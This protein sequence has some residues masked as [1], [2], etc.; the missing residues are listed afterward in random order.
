MGAMRLVGANGGKGA[1]F[2][3]GLAFAAGVGAQ[4]PSL[5][6]EVTRADG[7]RAAGVAVTF[8]AARVLGI[9][10][11]RAGAESVDV[12]QTSTDADGRFRLEVPPSLAGT[13]LVQAGPEVGAASP[14]VAGPAL[15]RITLAPGARR[16]FEVRGGPAGGFEVAY[17]GPGALAPLR[18]A[19]TGTRLSVPAVPGHGAVL[20]TPSGFVSAR[21]G[22]SYLPG[23]GYDRERIHLLAVPTSPRSVRWA[24]PLHAP[25]ARRGALTGLWGRETTAWHG[26]GDDGTP[27]VAAGDETGFPAAAEEARRVEV[28]EGAGRAVLIA[29]ATVELAGD[30]VTFAVAEMLAV[31]G[32]EAVLPRW[33][34]A[35][36]P[37]LVI[38]DDA[39]GPRLLG[40]GLSG[41]GG[42]LDAHRVVGRVRAGDGALA[43]GVTVRVRPQTEAGTPP[44]PAIEATTG[45]D[46]GFVLPVRLP[47]GAYELFAV[48]PDSRQAHA[49]FAVEGDD[50]RIDVQLEDGARLH[51][52]L[53]DADGEPAAGVRVEL[54]LGAD[55]VAASFGWP[56]RF[57]FT[58]RRGEFE[59]RGL[60]EGAAYEIACDSAAYGGVAANGATPGEGA[61]LLQLRAGAAPR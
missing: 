35:D 22:E 36:T 28:G 48:A 55:D 16:E 54:L 13:C 33:V 7:T 58:D 47:R 18:L 43:A 45:D 25:V 51:G 40:A 1:W 46:G 53:V 61:V 56:E 41:A 50:A 59:F 2:A 6:G 23:S 11:L 34:S 10:G 31:E 4:A 5:R 38:V 14:V 21:S 57:V 42:S 49:M 37:H 32:S 15:V 20:L 9:A 39:R 27:F 52:L 44:A 17:E 3:L 30:A 26:Q 24:A 29:H 8:H 60:R 19:A 12:W